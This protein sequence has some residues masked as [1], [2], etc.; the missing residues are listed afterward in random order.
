[1]PRTGHDDWIPIET[2]SPP[3]FRAPAKDSALSDHFEFVATAPPPSETHPESDQSNDWVKPLQ[4][5]DL[6]DDPA[7]EAPTEQDGIMEQTVV[8]DFLF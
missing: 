3:I 7:L 1:M 8:D 6:A 4:S 2:M 5:N